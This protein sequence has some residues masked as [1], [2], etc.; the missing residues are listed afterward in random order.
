MVPLCKGIVL[1]LGAGSGLNFP[2]YDPNKVKKLYALEPDREMIKLAR[3][4]TKETPFKITYLQESAEHILL[5]D[6][7]VDTILL[8][9]SL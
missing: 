2:F 7:S 8:T 5:K 4:E 9:Y 1:E 3:R 6:T